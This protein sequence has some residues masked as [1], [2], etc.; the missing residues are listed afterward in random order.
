MAVF[1]FSGAL[2]ASSATLV[3]LVQIPNAESWDTINGAWGD[4]DAALSEDKPVYFVGAEFYQEGL[5]TLY[6][7][8]PIISSLVRTGLT[9]TGKGRKGE[10][11]ID[12]TVVK[13]VTGIYPVIRGTPGQVVTIKIGAA[14]FPDDPIRWDAARD[15]R[16]AIDSYLDYV[17][18]GK[19]IAVSFESEGN[20]P[21]ELLSYELEI[22]AIGQA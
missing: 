21:W 10:W 20:E 11:T 15:F 8:L 13:E 12:P 9:I 16:I 18:S 2:Q 17:I 7:G 19:Y 5:G 1:T 3:G 4:A 6:N 14:D 22:N